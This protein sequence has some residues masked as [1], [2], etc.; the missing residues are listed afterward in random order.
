MTATDYVKRGA[1][2]TNQDNG[3]VN[4]LKHDVT[5]LAAADMPPGTY[6]RLERRSIYRPSGND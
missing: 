3:G 4:K 2:I 1:G 5:T 6:A